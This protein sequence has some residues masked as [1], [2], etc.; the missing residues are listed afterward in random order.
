VKEPSRQV[1]I[2]EDDLVVGSELADVLTEQG[3]SVLGPVADG[4][5]ALKIARDGPPVVAIV[6]LN[7][8]GEINGLTVA[9][10]LVE[11]FGVRIV[12]VSGQIGEVV[13]EGMDLTRHFISKPYNDEAVISAVQEL[14]SLG[15]A[16]VQSTS[17]G[18]AH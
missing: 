13:R 15:R 3:L 11:K 14:I 17:V 1:L 12:F 5:E 18:Q 9:R 10:H 4:V 6:D 16:G 7:L 8:A 2:V